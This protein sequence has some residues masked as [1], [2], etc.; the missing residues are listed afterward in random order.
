MLFGLGRHQRDGARVVLARRVIANNA[1]ATRTQHRQRAA[2]KRCEVT[3]VANFMRR[4]H[5][6]HGV[7]RLSKQRGPVWLREITQDI[8]NRRV[9][10]EALAAH[11]Q[12]RR[13]EIEQGETIDDAP[14]EDFFCKQAGSG[15]Q[16]ENS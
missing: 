13:G 4:L 6:D 2:M 15:A 10:A 8:S 5:R 11:L 14:R 9:L 12:E 3:L 1:Q 16:L 7:E